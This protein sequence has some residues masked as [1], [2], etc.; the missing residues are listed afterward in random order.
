MILIVSSNFTGDSDFDSWNRIIKKRDIF[1]SHFGIDD[2]AF[3][4][5][6]DA[7]R[8]GGMTGNGGLLAAPFNLYG[9]SDDLSIVPGSLA[10]WRLS[11]GD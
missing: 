11:Y 6:T 7:T 2:K 1:V 8:S 4:P 9:R 3:Q 10:H 5:L